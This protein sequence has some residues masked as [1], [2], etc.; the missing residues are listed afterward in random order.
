[1]Q[2][3]SESEETRE[4]ILLESKED[5]EVKKVDG[6]EIANKSTL[7]DDLEMS[8]DEMPSDY[9]TDDTDEDVLS[10]TCCYVVEK[11]MPKVTELKMETEKTEEPEKSL[12]FSKQ[13]KLNNRIKLHQPVEQIIPIVKLQQ[14]KITDKQEEITSCNDAIK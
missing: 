3:F 14:V 9:E 6:D 12:F 10:C 13:E 7:L 8:D 11:L 2:E 1:M 4:T 5:E